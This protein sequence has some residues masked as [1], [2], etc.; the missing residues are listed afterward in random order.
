MSPQSGT[1]G[2]NPI[3]IPLLRMA[4][5]LG[6]AF[7]GGVVGIVRWQVEASLPLETAT[8]LATTGRILWGIAIAGGVFI[9]ARVRRERDRAKVLSQSIVGWA[10]AE[11]VAIFGAVYWFLSGMSQW[12]FA[13]LGF[14]AFAL[15]A[16]PGVRRQT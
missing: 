7:L 5:L 4:F 12:Y 11:S 10:I 1:A 2:P 14:L 6:A 9:A 15:L 8:P 13:G 16:I 3:I